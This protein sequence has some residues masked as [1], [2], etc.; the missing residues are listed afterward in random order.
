MSGKIPEEFIEDVRQK[1]NIVDVI[2]PYVQLKKSGRNLFGLC[3]F[4]E[5]KTP[6]FSVSEEKQ[7]F[8][9][10][11]CG[12]GGNVFKFLMEIENLSFPEAVI[13]VA[14]FS[15]ISLP[16]DYQ[17]VTVQN[18]NSQ[19]SLL[20]QDYQAAQALYH[21]IL[22]KTTTGE[23]ALKYLQQRQLS[24]E[25]IKHFQIGY[26]PKENKTL[27]S[28][29]Q[30]KNKEYAELNSSGLFSEDDAGNLYD[31]FRD[32]VMFPI[33]DQSGNIVAFSG[34]ILTTATATDQ[35]IAKYL[36]SPETEIFN[37]GQ[38]LFNLAAAK[39]AIREQGEVV[40]FEGFMDVISAYQAG[41]VNGVASMGTSLTDQQL[42]MLNRITKRIVICY[43]GDTPGIKAA[44]RALQLLK[45]TNF[46][47]GVVVI[48]NGQDPDEFIKAQG[49]AAF[50]TLVEHKSLTPTA[51]MIKYLSQQYD[52]SND[53]DKVEFLN[54]ALEYIIQV[55][56][57]VEQ[58]LYLGQLA[59]QLGISKQAVQKEL[60]DKQKTQKI[61]QPAADYGQP[62]AVINSQANHDLGYNQL[63]S[64]EKSERNLLNI[65]FHFP[66]VVG[67][68]DKYAD[69][70]F[71]HQQ[72]QDIF[73]CWLRNSLLQ[74]DLTVAQ[75]VDL[76]PDNLRELV[77]TIE[78]MERP[79]DYS[80]DEVR[81][82]IDNIRHH[83][84]Q[85]QL[86]TYQTQIKQAA[87]IGDA[88]QELQL[89]MELIALRKK[90]E[91]QNS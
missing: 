80:E 63:G 85:Q 53:A 41:V 82:Y 4:H 66:E 14:D 78:M 74:T 45:S 76:V 69:F 1:T 13:K 28:F 30:G 37:K 48:P 89:T 6:S 72:Y 64:V 49:A 27:V 62:Q 47:V 17:A 33:T 88:Q 75:F 12:R 16:E 83:E 32:R 21:H 18:S 7:I 11:S 20:K 59:D 68:L 3:P 54:G 50:K 57:P 61:L 56:S 31:R 40:L 91:S 90:L 15:G 67:I 10:F 43:D 60:Q 24:L 73:D 29:F 71:V 79:A 25:T 84:Q 77:V 39:K 36:N 2:E 8:H 34:R 86:Q 19:F 35:P 81:D 52:L 42:Y 9:C 55:Q 46:D 58:E 5:E 23:P 87:Q 26:A 38:T 44:Q 51:F 70:S 65:I 22:L